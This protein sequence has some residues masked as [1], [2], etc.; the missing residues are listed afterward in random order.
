[1]HI[2]C[3]Y[4]SIRLIHIHT[5]TPPVDESNLSSFAGGDAVEYLA[6][7]AM[8]SESRSCAIL[9][10][11]SCSLSLAPDI[12]DVKLEYLIIN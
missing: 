9:T 8:A 1:M 3:M 11:S 4:V 2:S 6:A 12:V 5:H 10:A 7:V